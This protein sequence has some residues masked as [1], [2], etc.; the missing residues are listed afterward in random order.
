MKKIFLIASGC[1][2]ISI[3]FYFSSCNPE[4]STNANSLP[5]DSAT[6]AKGKNLF[7][8]NCASCHNFSQYGMGIGPHLAG[9]TM[10]HS[11]DW[12]KNFI[13]DPKKVIDSGD[14]TAQKLFKEYKA[15]MP[16]FGY[17][18][19]DELNSIIAFIDLQKKQIRPQ[20][21]ED[22]NNIK[23]PIPDTIK[24]S[25]LVVAVDFFTQ[26]PSS[27]D[28][29]PS[30][31]IIKMDYE[32]NSGDLFVLDLRGKLYKLVNGK[33]Q[34][35]MDMATLK[36]KFIQ[37]PGLATG[38]GS[39]A[40]HPQFEKTGLLYTTHAEPPLSA[41][42]DFNYPD[43]IPT[44]LQWVLTEWKTDPSKFP[45]TGTGREIFRIDMPTSIIIC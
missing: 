45:F 18:P 41:K 11:V 39:F 35:Y 44:T 28:Q 34:V 33:P 3:I 36:P 42:A 7:V 9:V 5:K 31:R 27:S 20:V 22:T 26:I 4:S 10:E 30:T 43:S 13:R 40:F 23:N 21:K 19:E 25:D 17:L 29:L 16:S 37:Q 6:I 1:F 32:P 8:N 24:T 12:L 2:L 15:I 14:T 38:F